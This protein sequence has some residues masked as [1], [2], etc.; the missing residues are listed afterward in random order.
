[1]TK[2]IRRFL[3]V[4]A[5]AFVVAALIHSGRLI[6]GYEHRQASTAESVIATVLLIALASTWLRP[7]TT[8]VIGLIAQVFALV[9]T[10]VGML[11]IAIGIGPRSTPDVVYHIGMVGVLLWGAIVAA[12]ARAA[13][14]RAAR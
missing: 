2:T 10:L 7:G 11:T 4:E 13:Q 14:A 12:R 5:A 8:P 3:L 9:G 6:G 1:M